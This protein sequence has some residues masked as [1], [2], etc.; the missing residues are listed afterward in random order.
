MFVFALLI[1]NGISIE[2]IKEL[3]AG[4]V[5]SL[6]GLPILEDP[7]TTI[8]GSQ[9]FAAYAMLELANYNELV[10]QRRTGNDND[11]IKHYKEITERAKNI[12]SRA[13]TNIIYAHIY[14][15]DLREDVA[16]RAERESKNESIMASM[17]KEAKRRSNGH[18]GDYDPY[19]EQILSIVA[20]QIDSETMTKKEAFQKIAVL[21]GLL[22][23]RGTQ[24]EPDYKTYNKWVALVEEGRSITYEL[25]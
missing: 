10:L 8:I 15:G 11:T 25:S 23:K 21:T 4:D 24:R 12:I 7:E 5:V 20:E 1:D 6:S 22:T 19:L 13:K 14:I 18:K 16:E 3:P 2:T 17:L 9:V